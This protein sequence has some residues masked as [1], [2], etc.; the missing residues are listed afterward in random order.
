MPK[1]KLHARAF[2]S[3]EAKQFESVARFNAASFVQQLGAQLCIADEANDCFSEI[4]DA[5]LWL[6]HSRAQVDCSTSYRG[7]RDHPERITFDGSHEKGH[8]NY[9]GIARVAEWRM[10]SICSLIDDSFSM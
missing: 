5:D 8:T 2:L 7:V 1:C 10:R 4:V 6:V 3:A 9:S